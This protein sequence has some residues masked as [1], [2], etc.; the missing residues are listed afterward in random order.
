[1]F[2]TSQIPTGAGTLG[3]LGRQAI[4]CYFSSRSGSGQGKHCQLL[5]VPDSIIGY[6]LREIYDDSV[7]VDYQIYSET[8]FLFAFIAD[9]FNAG[10]L[11]S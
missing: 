8:P 2:F 9:R 1:V 11:S 6:R 4:D 5:S 10:P 7:I 3:G